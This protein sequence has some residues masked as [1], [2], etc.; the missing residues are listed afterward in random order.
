MIA[1]GLDS[2]NAAGKVIHNFH[3]RAS[4]VFHT[5][6]RFW[7]IFWRRPALGFA[8]VNVVSY[9]PRRRQ[10]GRFVDTSSERPL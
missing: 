4:C 2:N 3:E 9:A 6:H 10:G 5:V 8:P 1:K 7:A